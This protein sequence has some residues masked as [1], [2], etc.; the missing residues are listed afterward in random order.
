MCRKNLKKVNSL[1]NQINYKKCKAAF[2]R[3]FSETKKLYWEKYCASLNYHS[4]VRN[5]WKTVKKL[6]GDE[7]ATNVTPI[8][9]D[10]E[11]LDNKILATNL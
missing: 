3:I 8:S 7:A 4:K 6:K 2:K 9:N 1:E 5:V 10:G 11:F